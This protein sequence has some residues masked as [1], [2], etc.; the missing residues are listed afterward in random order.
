MLSNTESIGR[1]RRESEVGKIDPSEFH[2]PDA[3][4]VVSCAEGYAAFVPAPLPPKLR[5]GHELVL[6]L[7]RADAAL[8]ELSGVGGELPDPQLLDAPFKRQEALCS[9]RIEGAEVSLSDLLLDQVGAAGEGVP[10]D[11]LREVRSCIATLRFGVERLREEPLSLVFVK[12]LHERL[13]RGEIGM[14]RTP[15]EFRTS[16]NW[17]GPPGATLATATYVPPPVSELE[18]ALAAWESFLQ[19]RGT[20]P[21]LVQCAMLHEQFQA[22]HPFVG[23]NGRLGRLLITLFLMERGRMSRP[24]LY[25]SAYFEG[26]RDEYYLRLQRVR[27]HGEWAP[28][29]LFFVNGVHETA[30]RSARQA[31]AL[32]GQHARNRT[33]VKGQA[34]KLADELFRMPCMTVPEA[35]KALG[36][37]NPTARRA[38]REL[39]AAGMLQEWDV[40]HWPRVY[41][42]R[43][44]LDA[45]LHPVEDLRSAP[46][47]TRSGAVLK[48]GAG[49]RKEPVRRADRLMAEAMAMIDAARAGGVDLR[50]TGGLAVRRHCVDLDFMDREYSDIDFVG[51]SDQNKALHEAMV[52]LGYT[53]NRYVAQSTDASQLQYIKNEALEEARTRQIAER[54]RAQNGGE[55]QSR[56]EAHAQDKAPAPGKAPAHGET[57]ARGAA[58]AAAEPHRSV[59]PAP[60]EAPLFDHVD[61]FMDVMRM[62][63]DVDVRDR[64]DIDEYAISPVDAFI[65]KMQIGKINQKDIHDVIALVKDVPLREID[66]DLSIDVPYLADVC[67]RDWGLYHDITTNLGIVI[68]RLDDYGLSEEEIARVYGRLA[69]MQEAVEEAGKTFRWR[70]RASVGQRVAWRREIEE[71]EGTQIIAPEWDWRRDLG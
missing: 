17:V 67:S 61:I 16:Q 34:L 25:L 18:S 15:G 57:P 21:D 50:L 22:I 65:A 60:D 3:G 1:L 51:R 41:L 54:E 7:S 12:D 52:A 63:H 2:S 13:F 38:V 55:E 71:T 43:P 30:L 20:L 9:S 56:A 70:L 29:L 27:T 39:E 42:A 68:A 6:A 33:L 31:R 59:P 37:T 26:H 66:D 10:R 45:V 36:V 5:Y 47:G 11:H 35:Q 14:Q 69:A 19:Q 4:D 53:E 28:W 46:G 64:L 32:I 62:D 44:V 23:G 24:L 8:G 58:P 48:S 49:E 40:K